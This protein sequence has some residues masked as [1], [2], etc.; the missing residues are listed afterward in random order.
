MK[1][2]G[3]KSVAMGRKVL[4]G[5]VLP[6]LLLGA[7]A[8]LSFAQGDGAPPAAPPAAP[9]KL[10]VADLDEVFNQSAEW[11]D[12]E[13]EARRIMEQ[14]RRVRERYDRLL[15]ILKTEYDNLPP[16]AARD[17]KRTAIEAAVQ[18]GQK[19]YAEKQD[20]LLKHRRESLDG[21]FN[22]IHKVIN[23]YAEENGVDLVLKKQDLSVS[24]NQPL[25]MDLILATAHVL[26]ARDEFDVTAEVVRRLNADYPREIRDR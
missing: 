6:T 7:L 10:V 25:E 17:K 19:A 4:V 20:L 11:K 15:G 23:E 3:E 16:G 9:L 1:A 22:K 5:A 14:M 24:A 8:V 12:Y 21:M 26:Y 2:N 18:D 13:E